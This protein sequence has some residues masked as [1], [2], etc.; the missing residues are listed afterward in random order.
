VRCEDLC[1]IGDRLLTD[2]VFGNLHGMLTIHTRP[3]TL[4][5]DNRPAIAFRYLETKVFVGLLYHRFAVAPPAHPLCSGGTAH[6]V[7]SQ[8]KQGEVA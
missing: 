8:A 6:L 4:D 7:R 2:I 5:G 3:L 1:V